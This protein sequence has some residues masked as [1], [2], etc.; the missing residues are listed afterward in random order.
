MTTLDRFIRYCRIKKVRPYVHPQDRILDIGTNDG[1][2]FRCLEFFEGTGIDPDLRAVGKIPKVH[3]IKGFFPENL[4]EDEKFD[5][6]VVMAV[7]EHIPPI[8]QAFF[9]L[10]CFNSLHTGGSLIVTVPSPFADYILHCLCFLHLIHGMNLNEHYRF[11]QRKTRKLFCDVGFTLFLH[12]R[13]Q[14]GLNNLFVFKKQISISA[15]GK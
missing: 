1:H 4:P 11:D 10:Q 9:A 7:I 5:V 12:K 14:F 6:I 2:L 8:K 3:L 15:L 13:F